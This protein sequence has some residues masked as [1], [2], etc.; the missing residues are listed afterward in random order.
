[1]P[2]ETAA[3][4][5]LAVE[6]AA[7]GPTEDPADLRSVKV[8]LERQR[9]HST[10][11][12]IH[13]AY[14]RT[15][16]KGFEAIQTVD[17]G[18]VDGLGRAEF[19]MPGFGYFRVKVF[20]DATPQ[21]STQTFY[22]NWQGEIQVA[23]EGERDVIQLDLDR[24]RYRVGETAVLEIESPYPGRAI[25]CVQGEEIHSLET[26]TLTEHRARVRIPVTDD[27]GPNV[28]AQVTVAHDAG[29]GESH[30]YSS[31]SVIEVPVERPERALVVAYENLPEE[32]RPNRRLPV[33]LRV[34]DGTGAA[35][36]AEVTLAAVDE[37]VHSILGYRDPDPLGWFNRTRRPQYNRAEYYD[38]VAF[39]FD[40]S[41]IGGGMLA[42]RLSQDSSVDESWIQP[43]ALWSG[44]VE[45][46]EDGLAEIELDLPEF[47]GRL[48]L[49]TVAASRSA[50]GAASAPLLVRRPYMLR[51]SL[52]RFALPGD[53][54]DASAVVFNTTANDV[55]AKVGWATKGALERSGETREVTVPAGGDARV[56]APVVSGTV[57]GQGT[58]EWT[59]EVLDGDGNPL[60]Q[61]SE[62]MPLPVL[63]PAVY[64]THHDFDVILPGDSKTFWN[65]KFVPNGLAGIDDAGE[66][67]IR[68]R[69]W[70]R[71][72]GMWC[73]IPTGV[74]NRRRL[75]RCRCI[76]SGSTRPCRNR[77]CRRGSTRC[78]FCRRGWIGCF[79]CR[80]RTAG[81]GI[82]RGRYHS[83][84]YGSVYACH[85]LTMVKDDPELD[86]PAE[87]FAMLQDYV[88][89]I[90]EAGSNRSKGEFYRRAYATY[91]LALDGKI[92]TAG[93][94]ERFDSTPMPTSGR[95]L[96]AA[97]LAMS[98]QDAQRAD[99]YLESF[100]AVDY[101][102][103]ET[104]G[105]FNSPIRGVAV[106]L[107]TLLHLE[108]DAKEAA[109]RAERLMRYLE[110]TPRGN[111][112]SMAFVATALGRYLETFRGDIDSASAVIGVE[113]AAE[114]IAGRQTYSKTMADADTGFPGGQYRRGGGV[115]E[116]C[117]GGNSEGG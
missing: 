108:R 72:C 66:W 97:A 95:Y 43:V 62:T 38:Q 28:W 92:G 63:H 10:M 17:A 107:L 19:D 48:R 80:R 26:V 94:I 113:G 2:G 36:K 103:V 65:T 33:R 74:W 104:R 105:N 70:R 44:T 31:F 54:F 42:K 69:D 23:V 1:M 30:P 8:A 20:S 85:F 58:V 16:E 68:R 52:P 76:C 64:E 67:R 39:D 25:V 116:F 89:G 61:L 24:P 88:R 101:S 7:I 99:A 14:Q 49:V 91:V 32:I 50:A 40:P 109:T 37:G 77:R 87:A 111:T 41:E 11:R 117:D 86:V 56:I 110:N 9:W 29:D 4:R 55:T 75:L 13:G 34:Q 12:L 57:S 106:E 27:F 5:R 78:I 46:D 100:D 83:H 3:A 84:P 102:E 81:W 47:N 60:D 18:L 82:G 35:A 98:T 93:E 51:A 115:R 114:R 96:L 15:W 71:R 59:V 112:Q 22:Q 53:A 21:Y 6:V 90:A 45:T 79:R 73:G